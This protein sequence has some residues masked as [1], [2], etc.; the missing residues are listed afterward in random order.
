[1]KLT[2]LYNEFF[3]SESSSGIILIIITVSTLFTVNFILKEQYLG[4]WDTLFFQKPLL[5]WV[6]DVLMT[7]F[8]LLIGFEIEREIYIGE[9]S[10][11]K[12]ALLPLFAA[13]GGMVVPALIYVS[14]NY[15]SVSISGF[16]IPMATDIAFSLTIIAIIASRIPSSLKIFLT[17]LAIIDD[18]GAI[19]IIAIFYTK[20]F[21]F[22]YLSIAVAIFL[23]LVVF[24]RRKIKNLLFYFVPAIFMWICIYKSGIH[25]T[26]TGILLAFVIPFGN[27]DEKSVSYKLQHKLHT[28][29]AYI[30]L[31]IFAIANTGILINSSDFVHLLSLNSLGIIFGLVIGKPLGVTLF[32]WLAVKLKFCT[33]FENLKMK[34]VLGAGMVAG[35]G[36]TMSIF[37]A[38]LAFE[39]AELIKI[40]KLSIIVASMLAAVFSMLFF[41]A[42]NKK[43][44]M[45]EINEENNT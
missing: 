38:L 30:I 2:K 22:L 4:F 1:M 8:F 41:V 21:S 23:L 37:I 45:E 31:P 5:F 9:L 33:L 7:F 26:V 35:I 12:K 42:T 36:F 20:G 17:A 14:I 28:P 3:K 27:G 44:T 39:D 15:N 10:S 18:I 6:N 25:P 11:V 32:S 29:V 16:G 43:K 34:H 40:S 24:N 19:L 13:L